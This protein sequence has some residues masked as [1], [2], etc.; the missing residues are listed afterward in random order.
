[1]RWQRIGCEGTSLLN[2]HVRHV[3]LAM[4]CIN[5]GVGSRTKRLVT[6]IHVDFA[7]ISQ[8]MEVGTEEQASSHCLVRAGR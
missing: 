2:L 8:G 5:T 1:M 4:V 6:E 7:F 3:N